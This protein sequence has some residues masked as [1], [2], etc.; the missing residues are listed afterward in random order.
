MDLN[1]FFRKR[2]KDGYESVKNVMTSKNP[3][4][5]TQKEQEQIQLAKEEVIKRIKDGRIKIILG[6]DSPDTS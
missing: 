4:S 2:V 1:I 5:S 3:N 6:Y